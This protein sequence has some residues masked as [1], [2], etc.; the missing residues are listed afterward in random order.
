MAARVPRATGGA[1]AGAVRV[2]KITHNGKVRLVAVTGLESYPEGLVMDQATFELLR[3]SLE[4]K[5]G[6][7][8]VVER[9][10]TREE[11]AMVAVLST[12]LLGVRP[13][14]GNGAG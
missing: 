6:P 14:R 11:L 7:P 4:R 1:G 5:Y 9:E 3:Q 12:Q 13:K 2:E 8:E 10:A